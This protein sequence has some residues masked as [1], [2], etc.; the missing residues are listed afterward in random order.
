M[1]FIT[2]AD[3]QPFCPNVPIETLD[4]I[5]TN[6]D[7]MFCD[8]LPLRLEERELS[9]EKWQVFSRDGWRLIATNLLNIQSAKNEQDVEIDPIKID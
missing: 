4:A 3:L 6:V 9:F 2:G 5:A 1:A 7:N 8:L